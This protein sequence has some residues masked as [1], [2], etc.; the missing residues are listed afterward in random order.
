MLSIHLRCCTP[1]NTPLTKSSPP[2]VGVM[3]LL[4]TQSNQRLDADCV[5]NL[6]QPSYRHGLIIRF[7]VSADDL[8]ADAEPARK[9]SLRNALRNP[10]LRNKRRDLVQPLNIR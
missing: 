2:L 7:F 9:I 6:L 10:Y 3:K 4:G 8:L 5:E 1:F